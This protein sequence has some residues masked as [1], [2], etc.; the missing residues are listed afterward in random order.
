MGTCQAGRSR[1][2]Y[3]G[4]QAPH[5]V[6]IRG[7]WCR[8]R[9]PL[10]AP[11]PLRTTVFPPRQALTRVHL[12]CMARHQI[13]DTMLANLQHAS[14]RDFRV[15]RSPGESDRAVASQDVVYCSSPR[16]EGFINTCQVKNTKHKLRRLVATQGVSS[17]RG[18]SCA[19]PHIPCSSDEM[20]YNVASS[21]R[22]RSDPLGQLRHRLPSS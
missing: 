10:F 16:E 15:V 13:L 6:G 9:L 14:T 4:K 7:G 22:E 12:F 18:S 2:P 3:H 21:A 19:H 17:S 1:Y 5:R 11:R 8:T 20:H